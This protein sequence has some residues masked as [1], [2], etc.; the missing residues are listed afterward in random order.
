VPEPVRGKPVCGVIVTYAGDPGRGAEV[1]RPLVEWG[2]PAMAMVDRM[3]YVAVQQ[4]IN[5]GNPW[6]MQNYWKADFLPEM[7]DEAIDTWVDHASRCPSPLTTMLLVPGGGAIENVADE[8][9]PLGIRGAKWNYHC[10]GMWP[11][12]AA[13]DEN[14]AW[15]RGLA[16]A[17]KPWASE[18]TYL[19]FIGDEGEE[20]VRT[21]FG[22]EKYRRLVAAKD[23]YDPTNMFRMNQN[24]RPSAEA[25]ARAEQSG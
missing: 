2:P 4:L 5:A 11:D 25:M 10:V 7:P 20:R 17:M 24:I 6:G 8:E 21:A 14:V 18:E 12:P 22:G 13:T 23:A 9:T 19:N 16:E 1:L 15:V 3:P